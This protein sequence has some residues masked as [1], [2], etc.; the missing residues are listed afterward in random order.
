MNTEHI[1]LVFNGLYDRISGNETYA[2]RY[3]GGVLWANE[4]S[5]MFVSGNEGFLDNVSGS[6]KKAWEYI[7]RLLLSIKEK[8]A[9]FFKG[10]K[11]KAVEKALDE[12]AAEKTFETTPEIKEKLSKISKKIEETVGILNLIDNNIKKARGYLEADSLLSNLLLPHVSMLES[13]KNR[14]VKSLTIIDSGIGDK[15][16]ADLL[17][18]CKTT[19][20]VIN[21]FPAKYNPAADAIKTAISNVERV[22]TV[23][24]EV[25]Q[26]RIR[27]LKSTLSGLDVL[28]SQMAVATNLIEKIAKVK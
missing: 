28:G 6:I 25:V 20:N 4:P 23:S 1:E 19:L 10:E 12:A 5:T 21:N 24:S 3:L 17:F 14:L 8:F 16:S 22:S 11:T 26:G 27:A 18:K 15:L 13:E 7:K 2:S 9:S